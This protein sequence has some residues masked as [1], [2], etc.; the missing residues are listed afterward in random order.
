MMLDYRTLF[1]EK[2]NYHNALQIKGQIGNTGKTG[3]VCR[4]TSKAFN[5]GKEELAIK[6][7]LDGLD[8]DTEKII[9]RLLY[10][11]LQYQPNLFVPK[12]F[13]V[14]ANNKRVGYA[15][16]LAQG[17]QSLET[18]YNSTERYDLDYGV[19]FAIQLCDLIN[20]IHQE[21]F[22]IGDLSPFN[23]MVNENKDLI[24]IDCD[25]FGYL[26]E[27]P[28]FVPIG[29]YAP[30]ERYQGRSSDLFMAGI[31]LAQLLLGV[32]PF[33]GVRQGS[34]SSM[35]ETNIQNGYSWLWDKEVQLA[36]GTRF[37][38]LP[39]QLL[40]ELKRLLSPSVNTRPTSLFNIKQE[41]LAF[42]NNHYQIP[43]SI[44][45][46]AEVGKSKVSSYD[47]EIRRQRNNLLGWIFPVGS[48]SSF[49]I[50]I[51]NLKNVYQFGLPRESLVLFE[52][53]ITSIA[54]A[55]F[56]FVLGKFTWIHDDT[57][58][59][60]QIEDFPFF[61]GKLLVFS[62]F[63]VIIYFCYGNFWVTIPLSILMIISSLIELWFI[64]AKNK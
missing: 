55:M 16:A 56:S 39:P 24:F 17:F 12:V 46:V 62:L 36:K 43:D 13:V 31:H 18:F 47:L 30:P 1:L 33:L 53:I 4:A 19:T 60:E 38:T 10:S 29:G 59:S 44:V 3:M 61:I 54:L 2:A 25:S 26:N 28:K 15:M 21:G 42:K 49:C 48:G 58:K 41:L 51:L 57:W 35:I 63:P 14:D 50:L 34:S 64:S 8:N 22:L 40:E 5:D 27:L 23:I 6:L 45:K 52:I 7:Y 37:N 32:H 11:S 20:V 9:D